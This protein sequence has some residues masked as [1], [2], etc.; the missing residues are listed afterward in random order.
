MDN[1]PTWKELRKALRLVSHDHWAGRRITREAA[2]LNGLLHFF[3]GHECSN[4][5]VADRLVSNGMCSDC[6]KIK[7]RQD[8]LAKRER[9]LN[10]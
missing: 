2:R 8:T 5:H 9:E 3:T 4:G 10:Q 6:M 7:Y 1:A